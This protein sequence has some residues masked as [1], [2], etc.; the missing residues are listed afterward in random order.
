M[1]YSLHMG[2]ESASAIPAGVI[3][4]GAIR[5]RPSLA[6]RV[7]GVLI[8]G[9]APVVVQS[10][11]NTGTADVAPTVAHVPPGMVRDVGLPPFCRPRPNPVPRVAES[12]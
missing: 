11:T 3:P 5:R 2:N 9:G 4:A 6:T 10:M 8:G 7:G 12:R 1:G